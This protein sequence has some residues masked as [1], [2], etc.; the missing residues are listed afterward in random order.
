[1][2]LNADVTAKITS[3]LIV[4]QICFSNL[5]APHVETLRS[6]PAFR[7]VACRK[8]HNVAKH[9]CMTRMDIEI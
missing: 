6:Y 2:R 7:D 5:I 8:I 3:F 9:P 4:C 1:M